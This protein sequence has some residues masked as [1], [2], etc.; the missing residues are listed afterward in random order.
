MYTDIPLLILYG[1]IFKYEIFKPRVISVYESGVISKKNSTLKCYSFSSFCALSVRTNRF[2][3]LQHI[4]GAAA[5]EC[6]SADH[7]KRRMLHCEQ[8]C[9]KAGSHQG[10]F[11]QTLKESI[12]SFYSGLLPSQSSLHT[13]PQSLSSVRTQVKQKRTHTQKTVAYS[14]L[15]LNTTYI[16]YC[17]F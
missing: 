15:Q 9:F 12:L 6:C 17:H 13:S 11:S 1:I 5:V 16:S 2:S 3:Q 7:L 8:L 10:R 14:Q 4:Y